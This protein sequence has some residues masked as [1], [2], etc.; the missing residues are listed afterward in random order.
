VETFVQANK[1]DVHMHA[2][3]QD[4]FRYRY[5]Y[6]NLTLIC[7]FLIYIIYYYETILIWMGYRR[8]IFLRIFLEIKD[9]YGE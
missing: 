7:L 2:K 3:F 4:V 1:Y 6:M 8:P 9:I 5:F